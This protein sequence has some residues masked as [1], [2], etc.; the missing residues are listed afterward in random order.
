MTASGRYPRLPESGWKHLPRPGTD[1]LRHTHVDG[2]V[3]MLGYGLTYM[4]SVQLQVIES[5][6]KD[7]ADRYRRRWNRV[8]GGETD[9]EAALKTVEREWLRRRSLVNDGALLQ[10]WTAASGTS[11]PDAWT[12]EDARTLETRWASF[13]EEEP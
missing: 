4:P 7:A 13:L 8:P 1:V 11:T 2:L 5:M 6:L 3:L 9:I 12:A 10:R